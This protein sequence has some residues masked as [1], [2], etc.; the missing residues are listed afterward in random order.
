MN[1]HISINI[2]NTMEWS[3][4]YSLFVV[5]WFGIYHSKRLY[6]IMGG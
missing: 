6:G 4:K 3:T 2:I 1:K 5:V